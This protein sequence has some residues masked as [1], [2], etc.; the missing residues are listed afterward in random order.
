MVEYKVRP[1]GGGL[2]QTDSAAAEEGVKPRVAEEIVT[3]HH[4]AEM[5][6]GRMRAIVAVGT[7]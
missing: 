5:L 3:H 2:D 1:C 6:F 7:P 4:R